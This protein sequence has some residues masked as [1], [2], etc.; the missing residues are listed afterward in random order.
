MGRRAQAR[1]VAVDLEPGGAVAP[2]AEIADDLILDA[3]EQERRARIARGGRAPVVARGVEALGDE[4]DADQRVGRAADAPPEPAILASR[5]IVLSRLLRP[6]ARAVLGAAQL[7]HPGM[8]GIEADPPVEAVA[9]EI[10]EPA[11]AAQIALERL[12]HLQ[13]EILGMA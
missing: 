8:R 10:H 3:R 9:A 2:G 11:A 13:R 4:A 6:G 1:V 5:V 12:Q 7:D